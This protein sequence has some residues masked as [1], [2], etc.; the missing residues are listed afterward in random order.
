MQT[1]DVIIVGGGM[2]GS[3]LALA[4][5]RSGIATALVEQQTL[6]ASTVCARDTWQ[7]RVSALTEA[8]IKLFKYLDAWDDM[9]LQRVCPYT[10]MVVW[11]GEGTG[12]IEFD[13]QSLP[14]QHLGYIVENDVIRNG[15]LRQLTSSTVQCFGEQA[16]PE[17]RL[18]GQGGEI[19]LHNG[20]VLSAPLLVAADG[21]ESRLRQLAGIPSSQKDYRHHALVTTVEI[22]HCHHYTARQ[23]FLDSGPL[24]LLPLQGWDERHFCSVVWSLLPTEADRI[25]TLSDEAFC[26]ELQRAFESR[27]GTIL[28]ADKRFR[29]SLRQ[30]HARQYHRQGVVLVGDAAHTIHPLAGQGVNLGFMDVAVLTEELASAVRRGDDFSASYILDRYQRRRRGHNTLMMAA[31]AGFQN[32]FAAHDPGIRWIRNTGLKLTNQLPLIKELIVQQAN[33]LSDDIPEFIR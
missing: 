27:A 2:V 18:F 16:S 28:S 12:E 11:D 22:E 8:S 29:F 19:L 3:A 17:F 24:A 1:F 13:A 10:R 30:R 7:P 31:M 15:L 23:V 6:E 32:L 26:S 25:E 14:Q 21:A 20:A 33:G 9:V 4:L 5:D